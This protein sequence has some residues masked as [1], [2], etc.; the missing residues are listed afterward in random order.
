MGEMTMK[1][2]ERAPLSG[3]ENDYMSTTNTNTTPLTACGSVEQFAAFLEQAASVTPEQLK[4]R[5]AE[6]TR[7]HPPLD[8]PLLTAEQLKALG[9]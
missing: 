7:T 9:F 5:R 3:G 2:Q 8:C 4:A 6:Y 1:R